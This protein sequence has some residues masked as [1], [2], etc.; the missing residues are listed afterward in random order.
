MI[1]KVGQK[2]PSISLP[3]QNGNEHKLS[4]YKGE[5]VLIYFYPRDDTPGCTK[6]ACGIRDNFPKFKKS[7]L[8]VLGISKDTPE[9]HTKFIKKYKLPF[10]L[11]S[12]VNK[13]VMKVYGAWGKKQMMGRSYM[14]TKR[15]SYLIDK[16]GKIAKIYLTV[17]PLVHAEQ[18]LNDLKNLE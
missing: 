15:I 9:S 14:G 7:K 16:T 11:L 2:A 1:L 10:V 12:D 6:E 5:W 17:K 3:D 18:V 13:K 4:N 8:N